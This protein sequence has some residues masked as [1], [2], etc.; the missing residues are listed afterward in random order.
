MVDQNIMMMMVHCSVCKSISKTRSPTS[1]YEMQPQTMAF[2]GSAE[3]AALRPSVR[4]LQH[5]PPFLDFGL[6]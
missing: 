3:D 4:F 1:L 2:D 6:L 5:F